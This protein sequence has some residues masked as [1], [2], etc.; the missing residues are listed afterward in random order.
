MLRFLSISY[1]LLRLWSMSVEYESPVIG[2]GTEMNYNYCRQNRYIGE[3]LPSATAD[4][5][6]WK[7]FISVVSWRFGNVSGEDIG[8][9]LNGFLLLFTIINICRKKRVTW[10]PMT[11]DLNI[12]AV[13]M[14]AMIL[15][16]QFMIWFSCDLITITY[17][18]VSCALLMSCC[19]WCIYD[20]PK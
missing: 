5:G 4:A 2:L 20:S 13:L 14:M 9:K 16:R 1:S 15:M 19:L 3:L 10:M 18:H 17:V 7:V 6:G 11:A 8:I 12:M